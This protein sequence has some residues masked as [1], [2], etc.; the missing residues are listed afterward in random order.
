[1]AKKTFKH[2]IARQ[3]GK[4][5]QVLERVESLRRLNER[6]MLCVDPDLQA[7]CQVANFRQGCLVMV[8]DS[9]VWATRLRYS[10]PELL[11]RLRFE[12][13]LFEVSSLQCVVRKVSMPQISKNK[14]KSLSLTAENAQLFLE[15]AENESDPILAA[16]LKRLASR[17]GK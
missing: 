17:I 2:L 7:H 1:M 8:V 5:E 16:S 6:V 3:T 13:R 9:A 14:E 11:N 10:F 15:I 12:A 4:L